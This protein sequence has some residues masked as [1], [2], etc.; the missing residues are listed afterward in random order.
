MTRHLSNSSSPPLESFHRTSRICPDSQFPADSGRTSSR[1]PFFNT[2][3]SPFKLLATLLTAILWAT[4][5]VPAGAVQYQIKQITN[6]NYPDYLY[7]GNW[8]YTNNLNNAGE[9]VWIEEVN[10]KKKIQYRDSVGI[11]QTITTIDYQPESTMLSVV[12]NDKGQIAW[13]ILYYTDKRFLELYLRDPYASPQ[14]ITRVED[15]TVLVPYFKLNN[16]GQ[17]TWSDNGAVKLYDNG[18]VAVIGTG[19]SPD[20]NNR[21]QIVWIGSNDII[22]FYNNGSISQLT[23]TIS[24][25]N[26]GVRI[27]DRGQIIW[28]GWN[29]SS[30]SY[31]IFLYDTTSGGNPKQISNCNSGYYQMN[32]SGQIVWSGVTDN[33]Y[34]YYEIYLYDSSSN[35]TQAISQG[36]SSSGEIKINDFGQIIWPSGAGPFDLYLSTPGSRNNP[37]KIDKVYVNNNYCINNSGQIAYMG[38]SATWICTEIYLATPQVEVLH[39]IVFGSN[40]DGNEEIYSMNIDGT[41]QVNLTRNSG[42]DG[43]PSWSPN[44]K[45]IVFTSQRN[46]QNWEIFVMDADGNNQTNISNNLADDGYPAWSPDGKKIAFSSDR[47]L[48]GSGNRKIYLMDPNGSNVESITPALPFALHP[49]WSPDSKRVAFSSQQDGNTDIYVVNLQ[50]KQITNLTNNTFYNEY[51]AWSPDGKIIIFSSDQR[52]HDLNKLDIF[53]MDCTAK[54]QRPL[55]AWDNSDERHPAWSADGKRIA[56]ISNVSGNKQIYIMDRDGS[57]I[58]RLTNNSADD[59]HPRFIT[60]FRKLLGDISHILLNLL[61]SQ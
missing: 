52:S 32:N 34:T 54:N 9:L 6:N 27:N 39:Q 46:G 57:N 61:S 40:R 26:H 28:I 59:F 14:L 15:Y 41:N 11:I 17:L 49:A 43:Y 31:E 20:I 3:K 36:H 53:I 7:S 44:G 18:S 42:I 51:P 21:G 58:Q 24:Y 4:T 33:T 5:A 25:S 10:G 47:G 29:S 13:T 16:R 30:L 37:Q 8:S 22:Y 38:N 50:N 60:P 55:L 56:F 12:I 45:K 2:L 19:S 23:N 35:T 1:V 48:E